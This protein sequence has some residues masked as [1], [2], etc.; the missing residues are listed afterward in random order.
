MF[1]LGSMHFRA[2]K[3]GL[4]SKKMRDSIT[5]EFVSKWGI[6]PKPLIGYPW[7]SEVWNE[8][9]WSWDWKYISILSK[10]HPVFFGDCGLPT[11]GPEPRHIRILRARQRP[12]LCHAKQ[13]H[14]AGQKQPRN[15]TWVSFDSFGGFGMIYQRQQDLTWFQSHTFK[16]VKRKLLWLSVR[17]TKTVMN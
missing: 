9:M 13:G 16:G 3:E 11:D 15:D 17:S 10:F 6:S 4:S 2:K 1:S 14:G 8:S 7:D 5:A 12:K